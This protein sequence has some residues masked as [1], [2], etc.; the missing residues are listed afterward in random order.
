MFGRC[1]INFVAA[2]G[3]GLAAAGLIEWVTHIKSESFQEF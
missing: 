1:G 2:I 3:H